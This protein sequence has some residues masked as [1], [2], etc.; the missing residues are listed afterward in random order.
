M[1]TVGARNVRWWCYEKRQLARKCGETWF[2]RP[3]YRNAGVEE[4]TNWVS[5]LSH[6]V[7]YGVP[8]MFIENDARIGDE[9][10]L[11]EPCR[12]C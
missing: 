6:A 1:V 5:G 3:R 11:Q 8:W 10:A 4:W 7:R 12:S 9:E 2:I